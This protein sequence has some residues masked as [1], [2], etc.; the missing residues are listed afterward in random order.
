MYGK[1][2]K[3]KGKIEKFILSPLHQYIKDR[4]SETFFFF[5]FY[6][7]MKKKILFLPNLFFLLFHTKCYRINLLC[8]FIYVNLWKF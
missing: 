8:K 6:S 5:I 2:K 1:T 3:K 7:K 4:Y